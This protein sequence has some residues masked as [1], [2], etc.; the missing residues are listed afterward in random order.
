AWESERSCA[1]R[2][3]MKSHLLVLGLVLGGSAAASVIVRDPRA[4]WKAIADRLFTTVVQ[5]QRDEAQRPSA[6]GSGVLI[7]NGLA[8]TTLDAVA[9]RS[10]NGMVPAQDLGVLVPDV[11]RVGARVVD[12]LPDL[13]LALLLL[14]SEGKSL[15]AAPLA[16]EVPAAGDRLIAMGS[17]QDEV[18]V[19]GM[20]VSRVSGELFTLDSNKT[21]DSRFW[22][23]PL[24][25]EQGR[26]AGI[27]L[28]SANGSKAVSAR[29]IQR[30]LDRRGVAPMPVK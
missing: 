7:G 8:V 2:A 26:L 4:Q 11:G 5:V 22:G 24:F 27:Q 21:A 17:S 12:A 30:M 29:A 13:D 18:S 20:I 23:G 16:T 15:S 14:S 6:R 28:A 9:S 10:G 1:K 25:D 19:I 3:S